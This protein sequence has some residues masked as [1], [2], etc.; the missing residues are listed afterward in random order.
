MTYSEAIEKLEQIT[1]SI[2]SGTLNID[3]L[4]EKLKEAHS[5]LKLCKEKLSTIEKDVNKILQ[6]N[7]QK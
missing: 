1:S 6:S 3:S 5:L 2:E 7:E 4:S